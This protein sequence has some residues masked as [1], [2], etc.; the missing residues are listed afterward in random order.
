MVKNRRFKNTLAII[1]SIKV[2]AVCLAVL[3]LLVAWGTVYQADHGLYQAQQ[4]FFHSW[5]FFIFGF[6]P[7]PGTVLVLFVLFINLLAALFHRI[8][9]KLAKIGNLITHTGIMVLLIGGFF[10]FYFSRESSL[11]LKEGETSSLAEAPHSWELAV[12]EQASGDVF[13]VDTRGLKQGEML[14][15][16][17]P[18]LR[19][20]VEAYYENCEPAAAQGGLRQAGPVLNIS[21]IR[22]LRALPRAGEIADNIPGIVFEIAP[23]AAANPQV[24]LYGAD[25]VPTTISS[26]DNRTFSFSLGRKKIVLPLAM[27]LVDFRVD[28]Y[29]NSSIPRSFESTV[30]IKAA[31]GVAR[32]VVISMNK[33]LRFRDL[34]FFQSS[35][36]IDRQGGEYTIL[37]V[38]RNAGRLLPYI[39][40]IWI[41]SGLLIHFLVKLTGRR[42]RVVSG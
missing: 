26:A 34:T 30:R 2:T 22:A 25:E 17:E 37:A 13:A 19:L 40:G 24:L 11:M 33:P 6:I 15:F 23:A 20:Q 36:M 8:G 5:F 31:G 35:Y 27:T 32:E 14:Y 10:T 12:R 29:P 16:P 21:G 41:F 38:V 42:G 18:G 28:F 4:K 39:A 1:A 3:V 7:F 9:F